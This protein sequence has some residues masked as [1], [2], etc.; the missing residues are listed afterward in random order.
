MGHSYFLKTRELDLKKKKKREIEGKSLKCHQRT[1]KHSGVFWILTH[2]GVNNSTA[3]T[4]ACTS[5]TVAGV[6]IQ[7]SLL[8][9]DPRGLMRKL[10]T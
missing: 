8:Y 7:T 6:R 3:E 5:P 4:P 1:L 2:F 10:L 9:K